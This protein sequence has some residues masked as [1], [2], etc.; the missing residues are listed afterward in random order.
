M[1]SAL[2]KEAARRTLESLAARGATLATA[3]SC[4]G[5]LVAAALT[6]IPG[7]SAVV[8]RG[9]VTYSNASKCD[10]LGVPP[11]LIAAN[12]AVS[13]PVAR[14]MAEGALRHSRAD[15]AVAITGIAGPASDS[16]DKPVGLVHFAVAERGKPTRDHVARFDGDRD[17]IRD[18]AALTALELAADADDLSA[19][20]V[21]RR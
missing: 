10:M 16:S 19:A 7:S 14:A 5:G 17:S 18:Q 13:A 1:I 12:G 4:T 20:A 6:A 21:P 2:L 11:E 3:E 15:R 9:F 8:E